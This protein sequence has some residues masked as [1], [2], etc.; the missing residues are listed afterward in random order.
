MLVGLVAML[1]NLFP[2]ST[3]ALAIFD[4][5]DTA[6]LHTGVSTKVYAVVLGENHFY[7]GLDRIS[8]WMIRYALS[9]HS[10]GY[11]VSGKKKQIRP[12]PNL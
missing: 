4:T 2:H 3:P 5:L 12:N 6:F 11:L 1:V 9:D 10:V 7:P 8:G